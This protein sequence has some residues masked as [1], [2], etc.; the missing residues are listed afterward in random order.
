MRES[1]QVLHRAKF[2]G[3][4]SDVCFRIVTTPGNRFQHGRHARATHRM[5]QTPAPAG[6]AEVNK[7]KTKASPIGGN[8]I[9]TRKGRSPSPAE[10]AGFEPA[11]GGKSPYA[12]LANRCNQPLCHLSGTSSFT[13]DPTLRQ[14][15]ADMRLPWYLDLIVL[16]HGNRPSI[17]RWPG[18]Q[19]RV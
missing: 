7:K 8:P 13:T 3:I 5:G 19:V 9:S 11:I 6:E 12:G 4:P 16:P 10:R 18:D 17:H 14:P 15:A 2:W 1:T